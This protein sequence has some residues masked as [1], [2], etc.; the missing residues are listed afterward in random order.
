[1]DMN[2]YCPSNIFFASGALSRLPEVVRMYDGTKV[3]FITDPGIVKIG[4]A[5]RALKLLEDGGISFFVFNEV[6]SDPSD[7]LCTDIYRRAKNQKCDVIVAIGG[8]STLDAAKAVN[9]L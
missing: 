3:L 2:F 5:A 6:T 1:M 9:I 7:E 8:G 4:L